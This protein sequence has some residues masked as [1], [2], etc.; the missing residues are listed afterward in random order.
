MY[1]R[2]GGGGGGAAQAFK[3]WP[4]LRQFSDFHIPFETE[5]K[6]FRPYLGHLTQVLPRLG[7]EWNKNTPVSYY[8]LMH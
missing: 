5:F 8:I 3:P 1:V 2:P 6:I 4:C 7:L